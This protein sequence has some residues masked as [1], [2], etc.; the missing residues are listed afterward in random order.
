[1]REP[2]GGRDR[3]LTIIVTGIRL[4]KDPNQPEAS[5][6]T[7]EALVGWDIDEWVL[8]PAA[9]RVSRSQTA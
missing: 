4:Q 3:T 8:E 9:F 6:G 2:S 5:G 7:L 1:M